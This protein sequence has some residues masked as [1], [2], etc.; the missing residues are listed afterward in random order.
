LRPLLRSKLRPPLVGPDRLERPRLFDLLDTGLLRGLTLV[1]APAGYGKTTLLSQWVERQKVPFAWLSLEEGDNDPE[2]FLQALV[3]ALRT[4]SPDL[5][6]H[7]RKTPGTQGSPTTVRLSR[8]LRNELED[9]DDFV[10]VLDDFDSLK[11]PRV[12]EI[13]RSL[14]YLP[15]RPLHLVL[16][17]RADPML[18]LGALRGRGLLNEIRAG[19]LRFSA[20]EARVYLAGMLGR[21]PTDNQVTSLVERTEG[22]IAGLYLAALSLAGRDDLDQG[23]REL[24]G[25]DRYIADYLME[26]L[27]DRLD[28]D[29]QR[30]LM[31]SSILER[32]S[33]PLCAAITGDPSV[34][35]NGGGSVLEWL[36]ESN[37]FVI[38]LDEQREWYRYHHLVKELLQHRLQATRPAEEVREL[39]ERAGE[40]LAANEQLDTALD[41]LAKAQRPE[42]AADVVE[43]YRRSAI[44]QERWSSLERWVG[45][46]GVD[47]VRD[48]PGL[49]LIHAWLAYE[50]GDWEGVWAH[51]EH[52]LG[53][54]DPQEPPDPE[55]QILRGEIA[56][57]KAQASYWRGEGDQTLLCAR[58]AL[59]LLPREY[60]YPRTIATSSEGAALQ[61]LGED[62]EASRVFRRAF[63]D[64]YGSQAD[65]RLLIGMAL[66]GLVSGQVEQPRRVA[67]RLLSE[68]TAVGLED[69]I[70]WGHFL[71]GM[72][73]YL[74][75]DLPA[76]EAHFEGV[77]PQQPT[78]I[79][80]RQSAYG[81]AW[82]QQARG[83][84]D[85]A[86]AILD[87]LDSAVTDPS[88]L[89]ASEIR[90]LRARLSL[91]SGVHDGEVARVLPLLRL[92]ISENGQPGLDLCYEY[93][94]ITALA[95]LVSAGDTADLPGCE[96]AAQHL[97][98]TARTSRNVFRS[99]QCLILQAL[100]RDRQG[101]KTE[102]LDHLREAVTLAAPGRL[103]RLFPE[104]GGRVCSLLQA[105]RVRGGGD[106]FVDELVS[107][108]PVTRPASSGPNAG[109]SSR[110]AL[111]QEIEM[112]LTNRE[113]DVLELLAQRMSNKEIARQLVISPAT[114]KRHTLSI[115][116]KLA[117]GGR[118]EAVAKAR[119]LG[120]LPVA[121]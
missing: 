57:L 40:W 27:L 101:C 21:A 98:S 23:I 64:E 106:G 37:L 65:P 10:L 34:E 75:N 1:S 77:H 110:S 103:V 28:P 96:D 18:P 36:E 30:F 73:A 32:L 59:A 7:V 51:C 6:G 66:M 94:P 81:L 99:I 2:E 58:E 44:D 83:R 5:G 97:L 4:L 102:A 54:L 19:D 105:L 116:N 82:I 14:V 111:D 91:V 35:V 50:R 107:S 87:S 78:L 43:R 119:G 69:S 62:E 79:P 76:A 29:V 61:M 120:L 109:Q 60:R 67:S 85:D 47:S 55:E 115:Y 20:E 88:V 22:W 41:H 114:V 71:I 108:F 63:L 8:E 74:R 118:R 70:A 31:A 42:L 90:L 104:M 52:A 25:S 45:S 72:A 113:M 80:A 48:R 33:A 100:I 56:S 117:V 112:L 9:L 86:F 84:L 95:L 49:V 17:C 93:G 68:A 15:P 13:V 121:V 12:T 11:N 26:E 16:S 89:L 24:T 38:S 46:L 39:H 53:L 3:S 92:R